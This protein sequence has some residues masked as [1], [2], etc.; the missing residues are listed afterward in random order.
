[1]LGWRAP[2][3]AAEQAGGTAWQQHYLA[4]GPK[5]SRLKP[6]EGAASL[7]GTFGSRSPA[8]G[9]MPPVEE[10]AANDT[11]V[12]RS[13]STEPRAAPCRGLLPETTAA[14]SVRGVRGGSRRGLCAQA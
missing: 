9:A 12:R 5:S 10:P 14:V 2:P 13:S 7:G 6:T 11:I 4:S 1:M 3:A 8:S